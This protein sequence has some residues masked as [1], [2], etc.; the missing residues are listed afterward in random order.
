MV[1]TLPPI[2]ASSLR[3]GIASGVE[4]LE[5]EEEDWLSSTGKSPRSSPT[6][7][8]RS[9]WEDEYVELLDC[10]GWMCLFC[11]KIFKIK[12]ATRALCCF[13]KIRDIHI[14]ICPASIPYHKILE[15]RQLRMAALDLSIANQYARQ[16]MEDHLAGSQLD[17]IR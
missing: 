3:S 13:L 6:G 17:S 8:S 14:A 1:P 12:H 16:D 2:D 9:I 10:G 4:L 5:G 15:Y 11:K 7:R